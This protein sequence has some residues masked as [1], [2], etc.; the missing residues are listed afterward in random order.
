[1]GYTNCKIRQ[2]ETGEATFRKLDNG[3]FVVIICFPSW[4]KSHMV[5]ASYGKGALPKQ[6]NGIG[7]CF[8]YSKRHYPNC[9]IKKY[10][11]KSLATSDKIHPDRIADIPVCEEA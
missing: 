8:E 10:V 6:F 2:Y 9:K 1:M 5:N 3:R 7:Q 4:R 11:S